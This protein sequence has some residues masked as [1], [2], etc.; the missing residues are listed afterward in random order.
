[1]NSRRAVYL[2]IAFLALSACSKTK[3]IP[4]RI[5]I[6]VAPIIHPHT[7]PNNKLIVDGNKYSRVR[8]LEP[9]YINIPELNSILFLCEQPNYHVVAH[10]YNLDSKKDRACEFGS[11][12]FGLGIGS[13]YDT[14]SVIDA[15]RLEL[16][17]KSR[18]KPPNTV[19]RTIVNFE[20]GIEESHQREDVKK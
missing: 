4:P 8:G 14:V 6:E 9:F 12:I 7:S 19:Y 5:K 17:S 18:L 16:I 2:W 3:K 13:D 10:L 1:M 15:D 11:L 20:T